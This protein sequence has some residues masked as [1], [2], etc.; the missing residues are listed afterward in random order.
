MTAQEPSPGSFRVLVESAPDAIVIVDA[1]GEIVLV[2]AQTEKLSGYRREE[3]LGQRVEMLVPERFRD[4]HSA[5]RSGYSADPHTRPMGAGL[6]LAG[7]RKDGT[8]FPV[9]VS[10]SPLQ[11]EDGKLFSSAI[12]DVTDRQRTERAAA[13]FAAVV[14]SSHDA[15]IGLDLRGIVTSWNAGAEH[16]YGYTEEEM[17]GKPISVLVPPEHDDDLAENL[18][19]VRQGE[20]IA[21][22]ETVRACKDGTQI[23]VSLTLSPIRRRDGT[24]IG[25]SKIAR[26]V[27][28]RLRDRERL[29][30][31]AE[32]DALTGTRNRWRFERDLSEQVGRARRYG[33]QAALIMIDIDGFKQINDAHGHP[34]G[35]KVLKQIGEVLKQRLRETD[36]AAR[37][38]GDEFTVLLPYA[39]ASEAQ[40]VSDV[41]RAAISETNIELG[42]GTKLHLSASVG[43]ALIDAQ[44]DSDEAVLAEADRAMYQDKARN[45]QA[46]QAPDSR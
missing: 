13:H 18:R 46:A 2:N 35:D 45:A 1:G 14:E 7:R 15:I 5:Q 19:R 8:E 22:Y 4:Q 26:D 24:V 32:H 38:G 39:G 29:V 17:R 10:L 16:L 25:A 12:R 23:D 21:E 33:E 20:R 9:E 30:F 31:L 44:T 3:L 36:I 34:A 11:T 40:A 42:N 37:I 27:T 28:V 41:L 6:E 43:T